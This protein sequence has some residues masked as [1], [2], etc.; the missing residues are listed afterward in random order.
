MIG[1]LALIAATVALLLFY[2]RR[3][4]KK[5]GPPPYI[6]LIPY[7]PLSTDYTLRGSTKSRRCDFVLF[8]FHPLVQRPNV[9]FLSVALAL[10]I[11]WLRCLIRARLD[12]PMLSYI[13]GRQLAIDRQARSPLVRCSPTRP[14]CTLRI[15]ALIRVAIPAPQS[16]RTSSL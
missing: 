13:M 15:R 4:H 1:G 7:E 16:C 10:P 5:M 14:L 9:P 6:D 8:L 2:R 3:K 11:R 12:L